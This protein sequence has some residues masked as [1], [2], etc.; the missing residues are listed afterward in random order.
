MSDKDE[1]PEGGGEGVTGM[2]DQN[3]AIDRLT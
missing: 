3:S 2:S 1:I